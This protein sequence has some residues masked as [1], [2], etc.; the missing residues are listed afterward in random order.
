MTIL[1][2][3]HVLAYSHILYRE[4]DGLFQSHIRTLQPTVRILT[5]F[6][7]PVRGRAALEIGGERDGCLM[8]R[9]RTVQVFYISIRVRAPY[10]PRNKQEVCA[11]Y[12]HCQCQSV[13]NLTYIHV[14]PHNTVDSAL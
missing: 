3:R 14:L 5:Y 9:V 2:Y 6:I 12:G 13:N 10:L 8:G 4:T 1:A 11:H 7:R